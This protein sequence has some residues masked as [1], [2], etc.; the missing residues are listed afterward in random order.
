MSIIR[1]TLTF[2]AA[3][4]LYALVMPISAFAATPTTIEVSNS[5]EFDNA[6]ATVNA[7]TSGE[8]IIELTDDIQTGGASFSSSQPVSIVGNGHTMALGQ[9][10]SISVQSGAQLSLGVADGSDALKISGGNEQSNDVPGLLHI[11]G[12]CNMH[13]GVTIADRKGDNYFGGGV[14]V[15][16]G[17]FHMYGGTI[18]N[19][20][21]TGGSI[22]YGGGVAVI[23]GGAFTMDGGEIKN[24]FATSSFKASDYGMDSRII[25]SAGGGVYV[26]GGSSFV[27]T[28]GAISNNKANEMGG[29]VAVVASID[30]IINGGWGNLQS[31]AQILGG[32]ISGNQA[33]DG[34]GVLSSAYFY[35][36]AYGLCADTPN[37]GAAEK[38]G[39]FLKNTTITN[40]TANQDEGYG[41]G[42]LA[43]MMKSPATAEIHDCTI[44]KN[45]AAIGGGIASYGNFTSLTIDGCTITGNK[46]SNYGGGFA[47]E[48]N[49]G[50]GA[51]TTIT[52][53]KLCNNS[54]DKAA[55]D[56]YL[57]GSVAKLSAAK[58]M[59]EL[60]LGKPDDATNKKIDGWYLD[61]EDARYTTQAKEQRNE[62]ADYASIGSDGKVCLVA[63]AKPSLVKITFANEDGNTIYSEDWY[64]I[65]TKA[66]QIT[67]PTPTKPSDDKYDYVFDSWHTAIEDVTGDV[68]YKAQFKKVFKNFS[69]KYTFSNTSSDKQLPSEV[70]AVLPKDTNN[71]MYNDAVNVITPSQTTVDVANGTWIFMGYDRDSAIADMTTADSEGNVTFTGS[72]KFVEKSDTPSAPDNSDQSGANGSDKSQVNS[73]D[74]SGTAQEA[75]SPSPNTAD[76]TSVGF[77]YAL[78]IAAIVALGSAVY[79]NSRMRRR[80]NY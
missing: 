14:T 79:A 58:D 51:G 20:G 56:A 72:W 10:G 7:A 6:V 70:L 12:T 74:K 41:A 23:Y 76:G 28:G 3:L 49:S 78:L 60:Y 1:R 59:N 71:Y 34:A 48:S 38:P 8:Y 5:S 13:P 33:N 65:G 46:A 54:A 44:T 45:S 73:N 61:N 9:Y 35:A 19:C 62:Y 18:D 75:Y 69:A 43:V 57:N 2:V 21:I 80:R 22:C 53:T 66:D 50:E 67:V 68:V 36:A 30:E 16:G 63:A 55:S 32:T 15:Q 11:E 64:E 77:C 29:G 31:S 37:V 39:L 27:M 47:A 17:T 40:N 25:T 4:A 26:S 52:N 24:C 42:V